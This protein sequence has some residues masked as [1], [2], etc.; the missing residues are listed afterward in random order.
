MATFRF[1]SKA[2]FLFQTSLILSAAVI[3]D[4]G[5]PNG[6]DASRLSEFVAAQ[7]FTLASAATFHS[8]MFF[9]SAFVNKVPSEFGEIIGFHI[10]LGNAGAPGT[11][12]ALGSDPTVRRINT[13]T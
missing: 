1:A 11:S 13:G 2:L 8:L 7:Q 6:V 9:G 5:A 4:G 3:Y 10:F 12:Q